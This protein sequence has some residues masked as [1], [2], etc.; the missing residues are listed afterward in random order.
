MA[1]QSIRWAARCAAVV[2]SAGFIYLVSGE[3]LSPH[4][5]PPT[6]FREFAGLALLTLVIV[7]M[8]AAWKWEL[9]GALV[10]LGTL[11]AWVYIVN[12]QRLG[13]VAVMATPGLLF[14]ADWLLRREAD[15]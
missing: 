11:A 9:P 15:I 14:I 4:S 12:M 13:I 5:G 1:L 8:L 10:S 3:L 2:V 7:A 6:Q